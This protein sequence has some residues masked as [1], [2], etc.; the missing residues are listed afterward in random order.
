MT[1]YSEMNEITTI[2]DHLI[3]SPPKYEYKMYINDTLAINIVEGKEPNRF[4]RWMQK[5][6]F[7][8]RWEKST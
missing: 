1:I 8:F 5:I 2:S 3:I 6:C 7:G 4:H